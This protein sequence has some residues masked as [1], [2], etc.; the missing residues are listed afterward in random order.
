[1][2]NHIQD[3]EIFSEIDESRRYQIEALFVS[4]TCDKGHQVTKYG[5]SVHGLYLLESGQVEVSIPGFSGVLAKL[6]AGMSFGEL[7]LFNPDDVAS[8]TV[9]VSSDC[10][11]LLFCPRDA[12]NLA[13][14]VD[15]KLAAG[16]YRGSTL[17][18]ADRL[19]N[20]NKKISG[21]ISK[22]IKM[23]TSL[24]EEISS[25]GDLGVAQGELESIGSHIVSGMT[26]IVKSLMV[27][28][29]SNRAIQPMEI[30]RLADK[31]KDIYYSD[32]QVFDRVNKQL[33]AMGQHLDNVNRIL[34]NQDTLDVD[35]DM[36]LHGF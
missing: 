34:S 29:E 14:K 31:A 19:K 16:F 25:A 13:L 6:E 35:E 8:A 7:S 5:E 23:A 1:M 30:T 2:A 9:T 10:A 27:M 32:F 20:T 3:I 33:N 4:Q 28:K 11:E 36:S 18:V 22:S 24:I 21:E 12:L 15:E 26:D 17:M